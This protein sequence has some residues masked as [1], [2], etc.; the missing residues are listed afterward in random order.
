MRTLLREFGPLCSLALGCLGMLGA[1]RP[2]E[3]SPVRPE[4][5]PTSPLITAAPAPTRRPTVRPW[6]PREAPVPASSPAARGPAEVA[7]SAPD[8]GPS[9]TIF[10]VIRGEVI[11]VVGDGPMSWSG[12]DRDFSRSYYSR[13][14][15]G[16]RGPILRRGYARGSSGGWGPMSLGGGSPGGFAPAGIDRLGCEVFPMACGMPIPTRTR[17][18][19]PT[20]EPAAVTRT[21]ERYL[22]DNGVVHL[23]IS[24]AELCAVT[25][26]G[27]D[28]V[29]QALTFDRPDE[30]TGCSVGEVPSPWEPLTGTALSVVWHGP[31]ATQRT[32][33]GLR[34]GA[35][36]ADL[37]SARTHPAGTTLVNLGEGPLVWTLDGEDITVPPGELAAVTP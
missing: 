8:N 34:D 25:L 26:R 11:D 29:D 28:G 18:T 24:T 27:T 32:I 4:P 36:T 16:R 33:L 3:S 22:L 35:S 12:P 5:R 19:A 30:A 23:S 17:G 2:S 15:S 6:R 7:P 37:A 20:P 14:R 10:E 31:G 21:P 9:P 1:L 13:H